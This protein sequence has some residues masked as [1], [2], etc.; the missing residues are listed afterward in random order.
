MNK[1]VTE[2]STNIIKLL[3]YVNCEPI[4]EAFSKISYWSFIQNLSESYDKYKR[5]TPKQSQALVDIITKNTDCTAFV[6]PTITHIN[7]YKS[8]SLGY[9][10]A[11][12]QVDHDFGKLEP[13]QLYDLPFNNGDIVDVELYK[14][15]THNLVLNIDNNWYKIPR[16]ENI[17]EFTDSSKIFK[18]KY[19]RTKYK[20][21]LHLVD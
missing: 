5:L 1:L 19:K 6:S 3:E 8:N 15:N 10:G 18:C 13:I 16:P 14:Y 9:T 7:Q 4:S 2:E 17:K 12:K 20:G 11:K 21:Y